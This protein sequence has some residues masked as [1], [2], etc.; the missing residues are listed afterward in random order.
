MV[1]K[2][3]SAAVFGARQPESNVKEAVAACLERPMRRHCVRSAP[4]FSEPS[5][6]A[7]SDESR[8]RRA[9]ESNWQ[10]RQDNFA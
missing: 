5:R 7:A 3:R 4:G 2:R 1:A 6:S 9:V 8:G 10:M